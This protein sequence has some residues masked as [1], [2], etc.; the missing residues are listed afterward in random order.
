MSFHGIACYSQDNGL[1]IIPDEENT[2]NPKIEY[3][4]YEAFVKI[5]KIGINSAP[6]FQS[7][8]STSEMNRAADSLMKVQ[9]INK[10]KNSSLADSIFKLMKVKYPTSIYEKDCCLVLNGYDRKIEIC[11]IRRYEDT[12]S[13]GFLNYERNYLVIKKMGY[14]YWQIILFN[15]QTG[16][17]NFLKHEPHFFNDSI[18]YCSDNNF[19]SGEF[20]VIDIT[21][22]LHYGIQSYWSIEECYRVGKVFYLSFQLNLAQKKY[23]KIDFNEYF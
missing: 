1:E 22:K 19:G 3:I 18:V 14:E 2:I 5:R 20:Q 23:I 4:D 17:Y 21:G 9:V 8:Y 11:R 10:E 15:P 12:I 13:Y 16:N 7:I 6:P